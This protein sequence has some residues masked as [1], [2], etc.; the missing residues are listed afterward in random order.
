MNIRKKFTILISKSLIVS[1]ILFSTTF[2]HSHQDTII[3]Y[4]NEEIITSFE[5]KNRIQLLESLNNIKIN[6]NQKIDI[7]QS[8]IDEKLLSQIG[9]RNNI[10]ISEKHVDQYIN[11][12]VSDRGLNSLDELAKK[13]KITKQGLFNY[14]KSQ[15]LLKKLIEHQ[16]ESET[17]VSKQEVADNLKSISKSFNKSSKINPATELKL[18]EIILYKD[19]AS[20]ENLEKTLT[21]I[22][23][24]LNEGES[25]ENLVKQFSQG[26]TSL[27]NGFI[28]WVKMADLSNSIG[29]SFGNAFNVG[30]ISKPIETND[31]IIILK[32]SDIKKL[33]AVQKQ[34]SENEVRNILYNQKLNLNLK[35]FIKNLRK[36]SYIKVAQ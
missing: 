35:N 6:A 13:F 11:D 10:S 32:I 12:I 4:V 36:S 21:R 3:A 28:G 5:L 16:I 25:Y 1:V 26:K 7:I 8:M 2:A 14:I 33:S 30:A 23:S 24:S 22:Y 34:L 29:D 15:L 19:R 20:H 9:R 17:S 27:N 18:C 31:S